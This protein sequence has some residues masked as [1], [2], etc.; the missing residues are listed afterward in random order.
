[1]ETLLHSAINQMGKQ[2]QASELLKKYD[3]KVKLSCNNR[4]W[5]LDFQQSAVHVRQAVEEQEVAV[6]I[7]GDEE[8]LTSLLKG[9]DFL[10][11]MSKRGDLIAEGDLKYLL[12]LEALFY[13]YYSKESY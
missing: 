4:V 3:I 13:L 9:E 2:E 5:Y 1:M 8:A 11:A 6:F 7:S 12:W 10:L